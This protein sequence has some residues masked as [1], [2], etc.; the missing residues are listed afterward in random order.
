MIF[1]TI[2]YIG[3][4]FGNSATP[5]V[6]SSAES[7]WVTN[8]ANSFMDRLGLGFIRFSEGFIRKAA[9]FTEYTG[10]G[11]LLTL[12]LARY[13]FFAGK[14]R[15]RLIPAGFLIACMDEGIQYFTPGRDCNIKDV[16]LDT[17]GVI[18]GVAVM[19]LMAYVKERK[20]KA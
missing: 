15:W 2:L 20:R 13:D 8:L 1:I 7:G 18:F 11:I 3:L 19:A 10:L 14:K 4:I 12:S 6:Y 9:H 17:C 5:A 16:L